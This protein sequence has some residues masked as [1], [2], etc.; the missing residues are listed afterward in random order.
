MRLETW[1]DV[2]CDYCG[3]HLRDFGGDMCNVRKDANNTAKAQGWKYS[4][5]TK[6][7]FCPNCVEKRLDKQ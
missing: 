6:Q 3:R 4:K 5:E 2:S 1:Y 7:N